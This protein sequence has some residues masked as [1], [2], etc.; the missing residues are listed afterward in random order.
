MCVID[1]NASPNH[2]VEQK[3]PETEEHIY[4]DPIHMKLEGS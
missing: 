3:Q 1:M 2:E 4:N